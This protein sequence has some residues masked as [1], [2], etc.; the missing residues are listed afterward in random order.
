[1]KVPMKKEARV[2]GEP[3]DISENTIE[4]FE[5]NGVIVLRNVVEEC[6]QS[7]LATAIEKALVWQGE[8]AELYTTVEDPGLFF[9]DFYMWQRIPEFREWAFYGPGAEI[10]HQIMRSRQVNLFYDQIFLK[11]PGLEVHDSGV[12]P[13]HQDTSY[14]AVDGWQFCSTWVSLDALPRES[15]VQYVSGSHKW[16]DNIQPFDKF[17]DGTEYQGSNFVPAPDFEA[18]PDRYDILQFDIEPGD[19]LVFQGRVV[20]RGAGNTSQKRRR[21]AIANRWVGDDATYAVRKPPAE[22]PHIVPKGV[23]H[24][25]PMRE[26][27][28][29][30]P[31]VWPRD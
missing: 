20:H 30:F 25:A 21:R 4:E 16:K 27:S 26:Y 17:T 28:E 22:F 11:E 2:R 7:K 29:D 9:N 5:N 23:R 6:W 10:A 24:G 1:M 3:I 31:K 19:C 12:T 13:W 8:F 15:T 18:E 14:M